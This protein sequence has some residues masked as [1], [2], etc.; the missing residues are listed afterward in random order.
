MS[1]PLR[2][3]RGTG[4][5]FRRYNEEFPLQRLVELG[6][7]T[8]ELRTYLAFKS[9]ITAEN[10]CNK[11]SLLETCVE[12]SNALQLERVS[13]TEEAKYPELQF[14][15]YARDN[16]RKILI[17]TQRQLA[18]HIPFGYISRARITLQEHG[19]YQVHILMRELQSGVVQDESEVHKL[20]KRFSATS[21][22][23]FCSGIEW[24]YYQARYFKKIRFDIKSVRHMEAPFYRINS[25][26]C[27]MWFE[28]PSNA[29]EA[30][31]SSEEAT[32]SACKRLSS[33]LE[34]QLKRTETENPS[35]KLKRQA[36]SSKARLM[37]MSPASQLKRKQNASMERG[38]DK[39]KLARFENTEITLADEQHTHMC[40]VMNAINSA[41]VDDLQKIFEEGASHGVGSKL[42]EI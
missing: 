39:R 9:S 40:D 32:C 1:T 20:L 4:E 29:S 36:V 42:K 25:V 15:F 10:I 27:Q 24:S 8:I 3:S 7:G 31:K 22:F 6:G 35:R 17:V 13:S 19:R 12:E 37:Y 28:L 23:K 5:T 21:T 33:D 11:G 38:I 2:V 14:S 26:N 30:A 18:Y 41:A 16:E 34:W